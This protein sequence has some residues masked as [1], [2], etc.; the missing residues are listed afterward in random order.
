MEWAI[1]IVLC[2]LELVRGLPQPRK[3]ARTA[4]TD[5]VSAT[6]T[7]IVAV[8]ALT[9]LLYALWARAWAG[10]ASGAIAAVLCVWC[11]GLVAAHGGTQTR[12]RMAAVAGM[13]AAVAGAAGAVGTVVGTGPTGLAVL[14]VGGTAAYGIPRLV[15]GMRSPSLAGLSPAYLGLNIVDAVVFGAYGMLVGL[16]GYV[17]Y[18]AVQAVTCVPV[19]A[20]WVLRPALR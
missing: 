1:A 11:A 12:V 6:S 2:T 17:G 15:T 8:L 4:R 5:G 7:A 3:I 16:P 14:L 9:W 10:V 13:S 19:L 18:A 20:R